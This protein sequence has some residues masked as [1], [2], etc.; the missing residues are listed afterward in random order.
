MH[1]FLKYVE[2]CEINIYS[3]NRSWLDGNAVPIVMND[4]KCGE[5]DKNIM[6]CSYT[7]IMPISWRCHHGNDV[8][9]QCKGKKNINKKSLVTCDIHYYL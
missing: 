7:L 3:C 2:C 4:V 6:D 8:A 1:P 9:L 5:D